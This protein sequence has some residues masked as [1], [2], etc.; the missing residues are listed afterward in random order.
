MENGESG[1]ELFDFMTNTIL[2]EQIFQ[3]NASPSVGAILKSTRL[4]RGLTLGEVSKS[5]RI[6]LRQLSSLEENDE[7]LIC[8]VYTIGFVKLYAQHLGLN[9]QELIQKFKDQVVCH[10]KSTS[11]FFPA[12]LPGRGIPNRAILA[13]CFLTLVAIVIGW[14]WINYPIVLPSLEVVLKKNEVPTIKDEPPAAPVE[15]AA[16]LIEI[17]QPTPLVTP[18][19]VDLQVTEEAWIEVKDQ[20]G[21]IIVSRIFQAGESFEFRDSK[22]LILTTGN[23]KGTHISSGDKIFPLSAKSG[24]VGRNIPLNPEKWLEQ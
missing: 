23:L 10:P 3:E 11:L 9:A 1:G 2:Q 7:H 18:Q 4:A 24:E 22:N 15:E 14:R 5:L 19:K 13:L 17:P 6:T 8:D 21:N 16:S 12:P 20:S